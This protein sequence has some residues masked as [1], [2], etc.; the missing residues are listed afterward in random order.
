MSETQINISLP[1]ITFQLPSRR[2][3]IENHSTK[4]GKLQEFVDPPS[5]KFSL[6]WGIILKVGYE[7]RIGLL[8]ERRHA[9]KQPQ[10]IDFL[11]C[12][13]KIGRPCSPVARGD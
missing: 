10:R 9:T 2:H 3:T 5:G 8:C 7:R 1:L 11:A 6:S 12:R 4:G 13:W